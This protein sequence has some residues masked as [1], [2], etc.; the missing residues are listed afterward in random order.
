MR[1]IKSNREGMKSDGGSWGVL[2]RSKNGV[3]SEAVCRQ[4][5]HRTEKGGYIPW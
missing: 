5:M 3:N 2:N 4:T 1:K